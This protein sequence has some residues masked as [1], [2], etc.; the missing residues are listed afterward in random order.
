MKGKKKTAKMRGGGK[1][2]KMNM[3]GRTGDMM[4]SRGY[5]V[6]ERNKRMPTELMT[7]PRMKKGGVIKRQGGGTARRNL[8]EE[9]G[10]INAERMNPNRRAEKRRVIGELNRGYKKGGV[11]RMHTGGASRA[12]IAKANKEKNLKIKKSGIKV[13]TPKH[14]A[15]VIKPKIKTKK[16][17][18]LPK[19]SKISM[20][21]N[22][23]KE[24]TKIKPKIKPKP[25]VKAKSIIPKGRHPDKIIG[26]ISRSSKDAAI[27]KA[28]EARRS[29]I[30]PPITGRSSAASGAYKKHEAAARKKH[31]LGT[32]KHGPSGRK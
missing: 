27:M 6:G 25:K 2:K 10:R 16:A 20:P 31:V 11:A 13:S 3:G 22:V 24:K 17:I 23:I 18:T 26:G 15:H 4:Y 21:G 19:H 9:V 5:G 7:A 14:P 29:K 12:E 32:L 28:E 8:L 30:K 1:V